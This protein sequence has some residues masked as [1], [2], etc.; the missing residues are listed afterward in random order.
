MVAA[1][2]KAEKIKNYT[3]SIKAETEAINSLQAGFTAVQKVYEKEAKNKRTD[4][5]G[6]NASFGKD[7]EVTQKFTQLFTKLH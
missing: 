7:K 5:T 1:N 3:K 6:I 2:Q 4:L